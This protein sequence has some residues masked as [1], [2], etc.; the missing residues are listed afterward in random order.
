MGFNPSS[1]E[2]LEV[3]WTAREVRDSCGCSRQNINA[4]LNRKGR[5]NYTRK[6]GSIVY[7]SPK[8]AESY[9]E[10]NLRYYSSAKPASQA[11]GPLMHTKR[12]TPSQWTR[13]TRKL[14]VQVYYSP[15]RGSAMG[16]YVLKSDFEAH[17]Q[18]VK[19]TLDGHV[20]LGFLARAHST[21]QRT[22]KTGFLAKLCARFCIPVVLSPGYRRRVVAFISEA[23]VVLLGLAIRDSADLR[24][25]VGR[26]N[27]I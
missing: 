26:E 20:S 24:K 16:L 21:V 19:E 22:L 27:L 4:W 8:V 15:T 11:P 6:I 23:N 10:H 1:S 18:P 25:Q 5:R 7:I 12:M 9:L 2:E 3:W 17:A 13:L 14:K